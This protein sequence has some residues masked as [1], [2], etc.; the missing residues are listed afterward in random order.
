MH[1]YSTVM[2]H[3]LKYY[4][5]DIYCLGGRPLDNGRLN[6]IMYITC[7]AVQPTVSQKQYLATVKKLSEMAEEIRPSLILERSRSGRDR[8]E[9]IGVDTL[10][11]LNN[12]AIQEEKGEDLSSYVQP[13]QLLYAEALAESE[14][15]TLDE[16]ALTEVLVTTLSRS[17]AYWSKLRDL[18]KLGSEKAGQIIPTIACKL[19]TVFLPVPEFVTKHI[20]DIEKKY[21]NELGSGATIGRYPVPSGQKCFLCDAPANGSIG[22]DIERQYFCMKHLKEF[23]LS[24]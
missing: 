8:A 16:K 1:W 5:S 6:A 17:T 15:F 23:A 10:I 11:A 20:E 13:L 4:D 18:L 2:R 21:T 9:E 24:R 14:G 12:L 22:N 19:I 7:H 3:A